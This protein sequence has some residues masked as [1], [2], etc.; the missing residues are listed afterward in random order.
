MSYSLAYARY[1]KRG[2]VRKVGDLTIKRIA[3]SLYTDRTLHHL[4]L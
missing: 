3:S 4:L 1:N 2:S